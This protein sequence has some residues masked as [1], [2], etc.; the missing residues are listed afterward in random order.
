MKQQMKKKLENM[1]MQ[2]QNE[3]KYSVLDR[4]VVPQ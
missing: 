3:S 2:S 4:E 1:H